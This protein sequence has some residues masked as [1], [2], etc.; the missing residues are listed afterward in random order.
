MLQELF[1][2]YCKNFI[3]RSAAALSF[4]LTFSVFPT[5]ICVYALL[6][7]FMP[8]SQSLYDYIS[9]F[10][11]NDS[12]KALVDYLGY[13]ASHN[14][15]RMLVAGL[16]LMATSSA[17]AFRVIHKTMGEMQGEARYSG[18]FAL[19]FSFAFSM[20]FLAV[21]YFAII[22]VVTGN[23]LL[24][25]LFDNIQF[26][27]LLRTWVWVR[28][29]ILFPVLLFLVYGLYRI[30]APKNLPHSLMP[31][32][33]AATVAMV[34]VSV[35]FSWF[36]GLSVRYSLVYGSLASIIMLMFWLYLCAVI[37][38]MGGGVN[39]A[40]YRLNR[41]RSRRSVYSGRSQ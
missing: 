25:F 27:S 40:L 26:I 15:S 4:F 17:S 32:A 35:L 20:I 19:F 1:E 6:G 28:F 2:I 36:I 18:L 7:S 30:T 41:R 3:S 10:I 12:L 33:V 8:D 23:W 29:V 21:I 31:G 9:A 16:L 38:L 37:L 24:E 14:S 11:P 34:A 5:L 13:V 39:V 22:V